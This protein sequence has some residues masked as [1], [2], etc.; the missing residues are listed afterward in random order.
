M[1]EDRGV[2]QDSVGRLRGST[3][4]PRPPERRQRP[5]TQYRHRRASGDYQ[6]VEVVTW[7]NHTNCLHPNK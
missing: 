6:M 2:R 7:P 4:H 1:R 5:I 3:P